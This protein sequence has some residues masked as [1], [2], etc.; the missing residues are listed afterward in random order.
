MVLIPDTDI[1]IGYGIFKKL[2]YVYEHKLR[3][4]YIPGTDT[5]IYL[6]PVLSFKWSTRASFFICKKAKERKKKS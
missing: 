1:G 3:Y 6:V 2:L 4:K 5:A